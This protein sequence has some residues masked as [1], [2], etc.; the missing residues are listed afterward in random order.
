MSGFVLSGLIFLVA[1]TRSGDLP[2][3]TA[4]L[5]WIVAC[6]IW[7]VALLR[8]EVIHR[9]SA[10]GDQLVERRSDL[11]TPWSVRRPENPEIGNER[12]YR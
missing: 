7:A 1:G 10:A 11:S 6:T 12:A 9:L 8:A 2:T 4:C 5:V 3:V